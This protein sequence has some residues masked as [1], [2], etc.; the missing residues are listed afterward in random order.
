MSD[1]FSRQHLK[2]TEAAARRTFRD[3]T[4]SFVV[5]ISLG[6]FP[7]RPLR[8]GLLGGGACSLELGL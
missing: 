4:I 2:L 1:N 8:A 7:V 3:D 5:R 6:G